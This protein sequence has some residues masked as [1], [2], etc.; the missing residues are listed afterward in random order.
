MAFFYK[1]ENGYVKPRLGRIATSIVGGIFALTVL[2]SGIFTVQA[3]EQVIEQTPSGKLIAHIDPGIKFKW[4]FVSNAWT[5]NQVTTVTYDETKGSA[6]SNNSPYEITFADTY[7][8][9]VKGS[10][11]VE[12][13]TDPDKFIALHKA[14]KRY[15]NFVD[16]GIEK[17]TNELLAYTA[18][19]FTGE[20]Y[21]QGGQ[22]EYK[23][24]LQDQAQ[25]GLYKTKRTA[26]R[27]SKQSGKVSLKNDKA[28]KTS[29]SEAM[30]YK[31]VVQRDKDGKPLREANPM[32]IYGVKVS[33]VTIDGFTPEKQL[34]TFMSNKKAR[35]QERATLIEN[36]ENERQSA[37]TAKLKG[38]RE[39]VEEKQKMLKIK[40]AAVIKAQQSVELAQKES[41]KQIVVKNKE[42]EIAV[43]NKGIEQANYASAK[44]KAQAVKEIGFAEAA[45]TKAKYKAIDP[46]LYALEKQVEVTA[47]LQGAFK[48]TTVVMPTNMITNGN[49]KGQAKSSADMVMQLIQLD[50]LNELASKAKSTK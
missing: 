34:Y 44:F 37:I 14:F 33:Q 21:M 28:G 10:F 50:K 15:D 8:G 16:N 38:D 18:N 5:Y 42:L 35:V 24:R 25:N 3:G 45:V 20:T 41:E 19:Q 31:N 27:V 49:G 47:N 4:P 30:I 48:G 17:F 1:E 23:S 29:D 43:A 32:A 11:R 12:L 40:D 46:K 9:H 26:V 13:P 22:N 39:R 36:Q 7:S 6:T 2:I